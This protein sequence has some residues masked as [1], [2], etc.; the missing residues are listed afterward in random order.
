MPEDSDRSLHRLN[1]RSDHVGV[2]IREIFVEFR[3]KNNY[4]AIS[5]TWGIKR[6]ISECFVVWRI[7]KGSGE[8]FIDV[9]GFAS[10]TSQVRLVLASMRYV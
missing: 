8:E 5:P 7:I 4:L 6:E 9:C 1:Q 2:R 10:G 3:G